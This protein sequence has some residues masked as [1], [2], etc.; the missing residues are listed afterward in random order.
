[1]TSLVAVTVDGVV[2]CVLL[3]ATSAF[4]VTYVLPTC[5]DICTCCDEVISACFLLH[6]LA[7]STTCAGASYPS[8]PAADDFCG[9]FMFTCGAYP[10]S[11]RV[12]YHM[13]DMEFKT[14]SFIVIIFL[15]FYLSH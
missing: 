8:A 15:I 14:R 11:I 3:L 1:M 13:S 6:R 7:A 2:T 9:R 5:C 10:R 12:N 4:A